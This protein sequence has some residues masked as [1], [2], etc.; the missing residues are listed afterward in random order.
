MPGGTRRGWG[1]RAGWCQGGEVGSP[2]W[3]RIWAMGSGSVRNAMSV[4]QVPPV[5]QDGGKHLEEAS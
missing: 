2:M 3:P 1:E 5:G 4:R